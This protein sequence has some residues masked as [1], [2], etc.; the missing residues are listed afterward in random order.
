[1]LHILNFAPFIL[2][3]L[4]LLAVDTGARRVSAATAVEL[5][6]AD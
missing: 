5:R 1:V 4:L 2:A 3:G 6:S